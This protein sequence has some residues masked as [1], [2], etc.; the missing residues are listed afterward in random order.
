MALVG[1]SGSGKSTCVSLIERFY[2]ESHGRLVNRERGLHVVSKAW[3]GMAV[4]ADWQDEEWTEK[5]G[6]TCN[7]G[8][9]KA[10]LGMAL[11]ADCVLWTRQA[12]D[13]FL[14]FFCDMCVWCQTRRMVRCCWTARTCATSACL[15]S[16]ARSDSVR[17]HNNTAHTAHTVNPPPPGKQAASASRLLTYQAA[18]WL[19]CEQ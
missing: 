9:S 16:A 19:S 7:R 11:C 17:T 12:H 13:A 8:H 6:F 5:R 10:R 14:S 2:G 3:L 18:V 15:G 4:C 1:A